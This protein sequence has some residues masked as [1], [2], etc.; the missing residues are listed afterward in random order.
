MIRSMYGLPR[1]VQF[2]VALVTSS[3]STLSPKLQ[4]SDGVLAPLDNTLLDHDKGPYSDD[5]VSPTHKKRRAPYAPRAVS[6]RS[7]FGR[8]TTM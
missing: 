7:G 2:A 4:P 8:A 3:L 6:A 5:E 1:Y